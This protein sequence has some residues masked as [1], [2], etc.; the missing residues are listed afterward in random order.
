[1]IGPYFLKP[2][3]LKNPKKVCNKL[4]LYL[5]DDVLRFQRSELMD[6]ASFS[7]LANIWKDGNGS[8][9][10]ISLSQES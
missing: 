3:E 2:S 7:D 10:K 9:L 1:M 4:F 8:P 6:V 5:W